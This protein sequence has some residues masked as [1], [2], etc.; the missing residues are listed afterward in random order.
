MPKETICG[1][2]TDLE[3]QM[4]FFKGVS[5]VTIILL[6]LV[7]TALFF[8]SASSLRRGNKT[9]QNEKLLKSTC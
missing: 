4:T 2:K 5:G 7:L 3:I 6:L 1:G 8:I 9:G